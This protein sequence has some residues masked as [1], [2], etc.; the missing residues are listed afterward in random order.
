MRKRLG[1]WVVGAVITAVIASTPVIGSAGAGA[2]V[3]AAQPS[4]GAGCTKSRVGGQMTFGLLAIPP[5]LDAGARNLSGAGGAGIFSAVYDTLLRLDPDTGKIS[6][7]LATAISHNPTFTQYTLKLR[8]GVKF[9]NGDPFD[10]AAVVAAQ[11]RY[12]T[13]GNFTGF[14][15]FIKSVTAVDATTVQYDLATPWSELPLQLA[16]TF[17]M[18]ADQA[19]VDRLG[20]G[21]ASAVNAGAGVGPYEVTTFNP[22]TSVVMKAKSDYWGGPVCIQQINF[23]TA[24]DPAQGLDSFDTGQYTAYLL[25][26]PVQLQRWT[27]SSPRVGYANKTLTVGASTLQINTTSKSAHLDDVRVR[28]AL[29]YATDVSVINQ[30]GYQGTLI[31]HSS[32]VPKQLGFL[33]ATQGPKYDLAKAKQLLEQ[34]KSETGWDGSM[35]LTC[36]TASADQ[37]VAVAA[38][39]NNAGFKVVVDPLLSVTAVS[40]KVQVNHDYDIA[41][42]ALQVY[43]G[44]YWQG[45][46]ARTFA[47]VNYANFRNAE[48]D[49]AMAQLAAAPFASSAYQSA[50]DKVQELQVKLVPQVMYG[51]YYQADLMQKSLKGMV[52]TWGDIPLFGKAYLTTSK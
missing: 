20:A 5:T 25:R 42:G 39:L 8:P 23:T 19:V 7:W 45:Y 22:P 35:H 38:L 21:F 24:A 15:S 9:T 16:Q 41:C 18:I 51:S 47:P 44:D 37:S 4:N 43:N 30:R 52:F 1:V 33:Q 48:W 26:D 2:S 34:V 28:Q 36:S 49:A 3:Q 6:P 27:Q 11:N 12:L 32:I 31:A 10:A 40:T 17:G 46:Y 29:Q 50:I 13:K 14:A